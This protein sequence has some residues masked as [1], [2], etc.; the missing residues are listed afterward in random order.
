MA[1]IKKKLHYN[2]FEAKAKQREEEMQEL[3]K[4]IEFIM[5]NNK[6]PYQIK[7]ILTYYVAVAWDCSYTHKRMDLEKMEEYTDERK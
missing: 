5:S 6:E 4:F 7:N 2:M 1:E 3:D